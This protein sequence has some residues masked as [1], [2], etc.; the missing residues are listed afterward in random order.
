[1]TG[2]QLHP[3]VDQFIQ[4]LLRI[5]QILT[6]HQEEFWLSKIVRV[7]RATE[8]S[9]GHC[10]RS[11]L[12]FFGGMGSFN[13]LVLNAPRSANDVLDRERRRGYELAQALK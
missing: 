5:E 9:D 4:C 8:N 1:M 12:S 13:D 6:E 11:F 3:D 10:V 2:N 7:R